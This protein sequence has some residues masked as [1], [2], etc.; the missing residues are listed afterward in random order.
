MINDCYLG[1]PLSKQYYQM[2]NSGYIMGL[3]R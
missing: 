3:K 1:L 2:K